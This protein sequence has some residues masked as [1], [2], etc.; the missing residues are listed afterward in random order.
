MRVLECLLIAEPPWL[1]IASTNVKVSDCLSKLWK[2]FAET[3][4][5]LLSLRIEAMQFLMQIH[6]IL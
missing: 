6:F 2:F 4:L 3:V 5:G 1:E